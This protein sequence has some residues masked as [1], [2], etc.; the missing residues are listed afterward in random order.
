M[1][2][3]QGVQSFKYFMHHGMDDTFKDKIYF[4]ITLYLIIHSLTDIY[5]IFFVCQVLY[6]ELWIQHFVL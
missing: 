3:L 5:H 6:L 1:A 2:V 4:E